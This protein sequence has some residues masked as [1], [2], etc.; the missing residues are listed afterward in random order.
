MLVYVVTSGAYSEYDIVGVFLNKEK[1][2]Y[3][4]KFYLNGLDNLRVQEFET[5][6]DYYMVD[7][8][9][10]DY[11]RIVITD[12]GELSH[13]EKKQWEYSP[14]RNGTEFEETFIYNNGFGFIGDIIADSEEQAIKIMQDKRAEWLAEKYGV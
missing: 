12:K 7:V 5:L 6:D 1:A 14:N 9:T 10:V 8:R 13:L 4:T 11:Y 3:F 2:E